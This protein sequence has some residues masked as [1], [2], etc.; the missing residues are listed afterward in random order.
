MENYLCCLKSRN[1][2]V[3]FAKSLS[4][5]WCIFPF[6]TYLHYTM[7]PTTPDETGETL[8][9]VSNS[10]VLTLCQIRHNI[11][12]LTTWVRKVVQH[13]SQI[14]IHFCELH[15]LWLSKIG[16]TSANTWLIWPS[17]ILKKP[18]HYRITKS[19]ANYF[20]KGLHLKRLNTRQNAAR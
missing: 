17:S 7:I 1:L 20:Q 15:R 4:M 18:L 8:R 9:N 2:A 19:I 14:S 11:N 3:V 5:A 10:K 13:L 16:N 6:L 12:L